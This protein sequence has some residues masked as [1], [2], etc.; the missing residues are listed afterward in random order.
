[1]KIYVDLFFI[2]N[3]IIDVIIIMGVSAVL[4]RRTSFAR[5]FA[6]SIVGGISSLF[7]FFD[8]DILIVETV[9][10]ILMSLIAFKYNDIIYT[11]RNILYMY[12]ISVIL[13]GSLYLF[14]IRVNNGF[15]YYSITFI[16]G[17]LVI[18]LYVKEM[19]KIR[20]NYNNY[21]KVDIYFDDDVLYLTGFVDTGNNL[22]DP[23]K[24]RPIIL[25]NNK[26]E[27]DNKF[28][29]VPY[30]TASGSGL[31]KCVKPKYICI[32]DNIIYDVLVGF[33]DNVVLDGVDVILH[34]DVMRGE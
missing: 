16:I 4:K 30:N 1:M 21:Y 27:K 25:I 11:M 32:D 7:L 8:F 5:I 22:Y 13:G 14:N 33:S 2:F 24:K 19:K 20:N 28:I 29:L 26:Y 18:V 10:I 17:F 34:R 9:S 15:Y 23:Y 3:I 6:S 12:L 31:L